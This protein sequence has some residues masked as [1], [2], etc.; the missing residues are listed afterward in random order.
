MDKTL[1]E[2]SAWRRRID[3]QEARRGTVLAWL[4]GK[5]WL[6]LLVTITLVVLGARLAGV[7][8]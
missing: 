4:P 2:G 1:M 3:E 8:G 5:P 7:I 6:A